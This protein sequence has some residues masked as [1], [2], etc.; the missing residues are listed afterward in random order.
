MTVP[1]RR[2][3]AWTQRAYDIAGWALFI[4]VTITVPIL[5]WLVAW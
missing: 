1:N 3:V 5:A 2:P 4:A